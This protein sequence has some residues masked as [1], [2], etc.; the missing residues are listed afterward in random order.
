MK[1]LFRRA[2]IILLFATSIPSCDLLEDCKSCY[3]EENDN[4]T[5]TKL[6]TGISTC[7]DALADREAEDPIDLGGGVTTYWVCK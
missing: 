5:I 4:G 1:N 2:I 7:G 6:T 3:Q